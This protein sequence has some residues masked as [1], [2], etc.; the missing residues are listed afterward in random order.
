MER[1]ATFY[2]NLKETVGGSV[3]SWR[4][5]GRGPCGGICLQMSLATERASDR[6]WARERHRACPTEGRRREIIILR[7]WESRGKGMTVESKHIA[8]MRVFFF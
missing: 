5:G 2:L 4:L 3:V 6:E 1:S 7:I 8:Y